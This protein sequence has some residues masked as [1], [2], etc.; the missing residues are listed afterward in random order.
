MGNDTSA[1]SPMSELMELALGAA[2]AGAVRAA[3]TLGLPDALGD[4]PAPVADLAAAV[5]A[6]PDALGRLLR[7][8]ASHGVF[9]EQGTEHYV[10]T[11]TSLVLRSD[12]ADSVKDVV[13]W[14]T[15]PWTWSLWGRLDEAVRTGDEM[16]TEAY[17]RRFYQHLHSEWPESAKVFDRAMTQQSRGAALALADLLPLSGAGTLADVGGG[18]GIVLVTLLQRHPG[19]R[20][21]LLDLPDV[22]ANADARLRPGGELG[23]RVRLLGGDCLKEIPV[24]ADVYLFKNILGAD[25]DDSVLI[26]RNALAAASP[27]ARMVIVENFVDDGPG[28]R[29]ASAM[30]LRM[31]LVTGGR[32]HTRAGLLRV[33]E[34]AGLTVRGVRPVDSNLH[35]IEAVAP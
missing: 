33:A 30:D 8:L 16:F 7:S 34:R 3:V 9:A 25:E 26:L 23:D 20:G 5:G 27:G 31:L 19:L 6:D 11:P 28:T 32:K 24:R 29:L 18:Q 1:D 2:R 21:C 4:T 12:A 17:G 14:C 22:V 15:E 10:H 13:L 35:M